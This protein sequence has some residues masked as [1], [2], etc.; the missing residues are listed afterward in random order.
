VSNDI[1]IEALHRFQDIVDAENPDLKTP[2]QTVE[3]DKRLV[4]LAIKKYNKIMEWKCR[5]SLS[6][7]E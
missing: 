2:Y 1:I 3:A 6:H 5:P 4:R 7:M